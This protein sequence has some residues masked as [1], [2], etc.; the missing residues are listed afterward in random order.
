MKILGIG[1]ATLDIIN[2]V[3]RYPLEDEKVR[4]LAQ[5]RVAGGNALN[6]LLVLSQF[7]HHCS[8]GG[9]IADD[10]DSRYILST[11]QHHNINTGGCVRFPGGNTPTSYVCL[12]SATGSRTIVHY[13]DL[14]EFS[15]DDFARIELDAWDWVHFEGRNAAEIMQMQK[16]L[17]SRRPELRCSLEVE[18]PRPQIESLFRTSD[19]LL[20][21]RA[22]ARACGYQDGAT[23]L[24]DVSPRTGAALLF[25]AWG[26]SGAFAMDS[27]GRLHR[28]PAFPPPTVVDTL[29]AG[30][31]FNAAVIDGIVQKHPVEQMLVNACRLAGRKCGT[32]GLDG[33][34][35]VR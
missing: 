28:S 14:P 15:A 31:V 17:K 11:L 12:S 13:R 26:A 23:L 16:R 8:W 29:G 21:S 22:Y 18:K 3:D 30:D 20:F 34:T 19:V 27:A 35:E 32:Q 33:I 24:R 1:T 10:P 6:T 9:V 25:C 2:L 7:G 5:R 4:T